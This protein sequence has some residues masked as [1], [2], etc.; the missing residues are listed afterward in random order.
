VTDTTNAI[1]AAMQDFPASKL[2][3]NGDVPKALKAVLP[4][5][6]DLFDMPDAGPRKNSK[7]WLQ[8]MKK[9]I[10]EAEYADIA[11]HQQLMNAYIQYMQRI[12]DET[13]AVRLR[14]GEKV[15]DG[16]YKREKLVNRGPLQKPRSLSGHVKLRCVVY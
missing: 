14:H 6:Q 7:A 2:P 4:M 12:G 5:L 9:D 11:E 13:G 10:H 3:Y 8:L 16:A 15:P 1:N